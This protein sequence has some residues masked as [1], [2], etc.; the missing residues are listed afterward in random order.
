MKIK[1]IY[2][3]LL[4]VLWVAILAFLLKF[5]HLN[6]T[7]LGIT[8]AFLTFVL[9]PGI[10]LLRLLRPW[11]SSIMIRL[12]LV[13][14]LGFSYSFF[15]N[16][17][18]ILGNLTINQLVIIYLSILGVIFILAFWKDL[19]NIW[20][21]DFSWFKKQSFGDWLLVAFLLI[22]IVIAFLAVDAQSDSI[23]GDGWFHLAILQKIVS[24]GGLSPYN[25]WV[26]ETESL[27]PVYSFPVWH[28]LVGVFSKVIDVS[29]I[30]VWKQAMLPM[31]ILAII[32]WL[33]FLKIFFK[34]KNLIIF[35]FLCF[36]VYLFIAKSFYLFSAI[37][38]PDTLC[39][40][41][42][43]PLIFSLT[44]YFLF[45]EK[46]SKPFYCFLIALLATFMGLVH[47]TQLIDYFLILIVL[48]ILLAFFVRQKQVFQKLGWLLLV[49]FVPVLAYLLIFQVSNIY[50]MIE[51]NIA[52]FVAL[53]ARSS[54]NVYYFYS[55]LILPIM[56]LF[57]K[58]EYRLT[59]LI[60][61]PL[62]LLLA[63]WQESPLSS[64]FQKY[65]G[66]IFI[67]RAISDFPTWLYWGF[68]Y[69]LVFVGIN[70]L[71]LKAKIAKFF[72]FAFGLLFVAILLF[73]PLRDYFDYFVTEIFFNS[74]NALNYFLARNMWLIF[75]I[76]VMSVILIYFWQKRPSWSIPE[77]KD[78]LNFA[79][80]TIIF[81]GILALPY[82]SGFR[83]VI[84]ANPNKS[85]F[86][87]RESLYA[88]DISFFG[89]IPTIDFWR[90][91]SK[92]VFLT[93]NVTMAQMVLLY[94]DN[95]AAEYPYAI[96]EFTESVKFYNDDLMID[97]R[98]AILDNLRVDYI[99][100]RHE[101]E[102]DS[103]EQYPQFFQ[104]AYENHYL[105]QGKAPKEIYIFKYLGNN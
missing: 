66:E 81:I 96:G 87:N 105:Y 9:S 38:T 31:T 65:L 85:V 53:E 101:E 12:I 43:L 51:G 61:I 58:K 67:K 29:H 10:F 6:V 36:L 28:I 90:S 89:G 4:G 98:L 74:N 8:L 62:T 93:D 72:T 46:A 103:L 70:V 83:E 80:L 94:S 24:G 92:E 45:E 30:T 5:A 1:V 37:I 88:S 19:H 40:L 25:L 35:C 41:L 44:A 27:N 86:S 104:K 91:K 55:L 34:S 52:T 7:G 32:V 99:I 16:L 14:S 73:S 78:K 49:L 56:S 77:P 23:G 68:G 47:F 63:A 76:T 3:Y 95:L 71:L 39:R 64:F 2:L 13:I 60:A 57:I 15:L 11:A 48:A 69:Y 100:L 42:L 59:L 82:I 33:G 22:G 17:I 75:A 50:Q 18:A 84:A 97:K 79:V 21:P 20:C 26:V 54:I 102:V